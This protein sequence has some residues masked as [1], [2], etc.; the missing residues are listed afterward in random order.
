VTVDEDFS[1]YVA[2]RWPSLVRSAVLLGC[3]RAEAEDVAQTTLIR[4]YLAWS[5]VRRARDRDAYVYRVLVN[6]LKKSHGRRWWGEQPTAVTPEAAQ[7]PAD[8]ETGID[9]RHALAGL[10]ADHRAVLVLRFV[11]DLS[12][13]QVA[14]VLGIPAGTVKSRVSRALASIDPAGLREEETR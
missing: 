4:C 1:E 5:R 11:A 10:T 14:E 8:L 12:E 2:A 13:R 3:Q 6:V 7:E 9:L